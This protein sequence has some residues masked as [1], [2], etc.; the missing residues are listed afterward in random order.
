MSIQIDTQAKLAEWVKRAP[1][2]TLSPTERMSKELRVYSAIAVAIVL[3]LVIEPQLYLFDVEESLIY[4]VAKLAPSPYMVTC[5][6]TAGLLACLPHLVTLVFLPDKLGLYWPR[7]AAAGGCF[8]I[9]VTWIY[10]A[11][12]AHPLDL[13]SLP[14]SYLARSLVTVLIGVCYANSVNEQQARER[15]ADAK[16]DELESVE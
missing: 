9:S 15:A 6:F 2:I 8:L 5:F 13:G 4:R 3:L 16:E 1:S 10:L 14:V 7:I 11:N 12:L